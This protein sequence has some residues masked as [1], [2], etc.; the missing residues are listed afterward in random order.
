MTQ[1]ITAPFSHRAE[2]TI[3]CCNDARPQSRDKRRDPSCRPRCPGDVSS[4]PRRWA[5]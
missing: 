4:G 5:P 3:S 2:A 1:A